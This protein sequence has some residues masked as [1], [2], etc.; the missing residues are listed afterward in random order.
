M[1]RAAL[2]RPLSNRE[3]QRIFWRNGNRSHLVGY[4][5]DFPGIWLDAK[6]PGHNL[7]LWLSTIATA[8]V[9]RGIQS[10]GPLHYGIIE[11]MDMR[12]SGAHNCPP[13]WNGAP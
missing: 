4:V 7:R 1:I 6:Q 13:R 8:Q 11:G 5:A 9:R 10:G 2:L 3:C 12:D